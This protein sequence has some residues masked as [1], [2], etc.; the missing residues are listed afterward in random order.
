MPRMKLSEQGAYEFRHTVTLQP[1]DINY[2]GHL[3]NDSL[4]SVLNTARVHMLHGLGYNE[5][6]VGAKATGIIMSDL[7][8]N[9]RNEAFLLDELTVEIHSGEF[10]RTGFRMFYRVTKGRTLVALAETGIVIF[11]YKARKAAPVPEAFR[12]ALEG[13]REKAENPGR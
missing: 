1:R 12:K 11:E 8:V 9:Y 13:L 3:R 4:I 10:S 5:L 2:G 6:D 7:V